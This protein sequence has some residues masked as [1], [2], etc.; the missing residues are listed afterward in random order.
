MDSEEI[1][2]SSYGSLESL[3][4][5]QTHLQNHLPNDG[6]KLQASDLDVKEEIL[7]EAR[8]DSKLD[9]NSEKIENVLDENKKE[10]PLPEEGKIDDNLYDEILEK[11]DIKQKNKQDIQKSM[12]EK[13]SQEAYLNKLNELDKLQTKIKVEKAI[14]QDFSKIQTL[15][16]AGLINSVQGQNLKKQVLKKAFDMLVQTE[17]IKRNLPVAQKEGLQASNTV[18]TSVNKKEIFEEF[19][20]NNPDFFNST[21][22][23]DVLNYLKSNDVIIGRD[24]LNKISEII[25]IVEKGAIDRYLQKAAHEKTL[26][27]SNEAAKQRL[28]ANAQKSGLSGNL[29]RTFTREQIG[30]MNSAEFTKY[31]PAIMEQLK[32]GLIK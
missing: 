5:S 9:N 31:E 24:E 11:L 6:Q 20:K 3:N 18:N 28:T 10:S 19:S 2:D 21:G 30:K 7:S 16:N 32:K 15:V 17:K 25:R 23:K 29:L 14:S 27:D 12:Q 8:N 26:R 22:R 4:Q 1:K 13:L